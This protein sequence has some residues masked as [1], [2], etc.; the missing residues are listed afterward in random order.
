MRWN[1]LSRQS[2]PILAV[3]RL[4]Y[5]HLNHFSGPLL[6]ETLSVLHIFSTDFPR[7]HPP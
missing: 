1:E 3:Q 6:R 7:F 4:T 2:Q 5:M